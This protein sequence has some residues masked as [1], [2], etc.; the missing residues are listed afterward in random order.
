MVC[1]SFSRAASRLGASALV[2]FLLLG[3]LGACAP[4]PSDPNGLS[5]TVSISGAF[6]LYPMMQRWTQEF[7]KLHPDVQFDV[8][9]GGAGKGMADTLAGAVD[10]GMISRDITPAEERKG[11]AWV[12]VAKDAVFPVI[13]AQ[14]PAA[15]VLAQKGLTRDSFA[16]IYI[17]G[18]LKTWG[19]AAGSVAIAGAIHAYTRSDSA[20]A[21]DTWAAFLGKKQENLLGIG[22][23][24]DPAITEAVSKDPLGI[25]YSNL[26]YAYDAATGLPVQGTLVLAIDANANGK[27][28]P[29]EQVDTKARA[30][31]L[32]ASGKYPSPPARQLYLATRGKPAGAAR[33]FLRWILSDGQKYLSET[34]YIPLPQDRLS[35]ELQK[36]Q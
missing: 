21:A 30:V 6:A 33:E 3:A 13:N 12:A 26:N 8:S 35:L 16:R 19:E 11:A 36:L 14:N 31:E 29:Q 5:G 22:V 18:E 7:N 10:I 32:V 1:A 17:T 27:V 25:G 34:G 20:G 24:G 4:A 15:A 28:D 9:A 2:L 23:S